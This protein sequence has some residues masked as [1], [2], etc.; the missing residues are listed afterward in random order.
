MKKP[1]KPTHKQKSIAGMINPLYGGYATR[2]EMVA[3]RLACRSHFWLDL[4][5][6]CDGMFIAVSPKGR[7]QSFPYMMCSWQTSSITTRWKQ[8]ARRAASLW[9]HG[10]NRKARTTYNIVWNEY[11]DLPFYI[12]RKPRG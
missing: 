1:I 2:K 3:A 4:E 6:P 11:Q 12:L 8:L 10:E 7:R 5:D 9:A